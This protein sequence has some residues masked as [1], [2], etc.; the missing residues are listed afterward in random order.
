MSD[1]NS[2]LRQQSGSRIALDARY[3]FHSAT[4]SPHYI[5][6][7]ARFQPR[8]SCSDAFPRR[9][10]RRAWVSVWRQDFIWGRV[11]GQRYDTIG[12][13]GRQGLA[14]TSLFTP[15]NIGASWVHTF[16]PTSDHFWHSILQGVSGRTLPAAADTWDSSKIIKGFDSSPLTVLLLLPQRTI[17]RP[18]RDREPVLHR[19][20]KLNR[21]RISL[22]GGTKPLFAGTQQCEVQI[23]EGKWDAAGVPEDIGYRR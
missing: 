22:A 23:P 16:S 19:R 13:G 9:N 15:I 2:H 1:H 3:L 14:S 21:R 18:Q 11:S 8:S 20:R 4:R 12:T 6:R 17:A 10:I 5:D 7:R